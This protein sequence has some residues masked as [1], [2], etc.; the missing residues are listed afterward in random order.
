MAASLC[1]DCIYYSYDDELDAYFCEQ[2]LDEDEMERFLH[3]H[4]A[5]C[6]FYHPGQSDYYLAGK[7]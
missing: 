3:R 5:S 7:Q 1:D 4:L 6:P 2:D